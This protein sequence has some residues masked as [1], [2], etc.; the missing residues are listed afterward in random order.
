VFIQYTSMSS[1][2]PIL[3]FLYL[4]LFNTSTSTVSP[5]LFFLYLCLFNTSTSTVSPSLFLCLFNTSLFFSLSRLSFFSICVHSFSVCLLSLKTSFS[6]LLFIQY[7]CVRAFLD[8]LCSLFVF[9]T[10]SSYLFNLSFMSIL[11]D[12]LFYTSISALFLCLS[13]FSLSIF[14]FSSPAFL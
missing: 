3:F 13:F 14:S 9:S 2:S 12:Y 7:L 6:F 8:Y 11:S 5:I 10:C 4:C 1:V